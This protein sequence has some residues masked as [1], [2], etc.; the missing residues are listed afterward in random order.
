MSLALH[1]TVSEGAEACGLALLVIAVI[2]LSIHCGQCPPSA[3][4]GMACGSNHTHHRSALTRERSDHSR[5]DPHLLPQTLQ[6]A[7]PDCLTKH[8]LSPNLHV[9]AVQPAPRRHVSAAPAQAAYGGH[10]CTTSKFFYASVVTFPAATLAPVASF[11]AYSH[12]VSPTPTWRGVRI[13]YS[14]P[15]TPRPRSLTLTTYSC[16]AH[17]LRSAQGAAGRRI[18]RHA[19]APVPE[20]V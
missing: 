2:P 18:R 4:T 5:L 20:G 3:I 8:D 16:L 10:V 14:H 13:P 11:Y 7:H 19:A 15:H 12:I 6:C 9:I 17:L 1:S